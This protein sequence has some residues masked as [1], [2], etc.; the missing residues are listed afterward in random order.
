M[1]I[2][3]R[4]S[5]DFACCARATAS[6][7]LNGRQRRYAVAPGSA[8]DQDFEALANREEIE[9]LNGGDS[10]HAA[11]ISSGTRSPTRVSIYWPQR[12]RA[13]LRSARKS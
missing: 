5:Q 11:A 13:S 2:A 4:S 6:A 8:V 12:S 10:A 1:L 7:Q 9:I 3:A